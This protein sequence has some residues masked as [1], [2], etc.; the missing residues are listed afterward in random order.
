MFDDSLCDLLF[1]LG[2]S[3]V[4]YQRRFRF[5]WPEGLLRPGSDLRSGSG[6]CRQALL[7]SGSGSGL[8]CQALLRSGSEALLRSGSGLRCQALLRSGSGSGLRC[9]ALLRSGSGSGRRCQA[10]LRSEA[11]VL[12]ALLQVIPAGQP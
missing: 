5:R 2:C 7:R 12:Q 4:L 8:R 10:L 1:G 9:Q 6:L 3:V 11:Y